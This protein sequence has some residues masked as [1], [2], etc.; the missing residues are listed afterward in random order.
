MKVYG[1]YWEKFSLSLSLPS[2]HSVSPPSAS[3]L[4]LALLSPHFRSSPLTPLS[5]RLPLDSTVPSGFLGKTN[6]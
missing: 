2:S 4:H 5:P 6:I 3:A 1:I